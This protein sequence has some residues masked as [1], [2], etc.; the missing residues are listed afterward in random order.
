MNVYGPRVPDEIRFHDYDGSQLRSGFIEKI[1]GKKRWPSLGKHCIGWFVGNCQVLPDGHM[2]DL[3]DIE[4]N[5]PILSDSMVHF[6]IEID[7][8]QDI[9]K[10]VLYQRLFARMVAEA[11]CQRVRRDLL[12]SGDDIYL[13]GGDGEVDRKLSVSIATI[14]ESGIGLVHF[15]MNLTT[16]GTPEDVKT[17]SLADYG[18]VLRDLSYENYYTLI[19]FCNELCKR[20]AEEVYDAESASMKVKEV[21]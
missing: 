12:I 17:G 14:S 10:M 16:D 11:L 6:I 7:Y 2:I 3:E 5:A 13:Q 8:C 20:Y 4:K 18:I 9:E 21:V 19:G 15:G 1:Y